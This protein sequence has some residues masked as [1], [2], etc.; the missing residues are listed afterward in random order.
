ML[1]KIASSLSFA[2]LAASAYA[3]SPVHSRVV[4]AGEF[5][6]AQLP[7]QNALMQA[8]ADYNIAALMRTGALVRPKTQAAI[9]DLQ[10]PLQPVAGFDQSG[11]HGI[12]N[13]VDHDARFPG[14][15]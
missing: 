7:E 9:N 2:L 14:F 11:Y 13:F 15:V 5:A 4:S 3:Q 10:W 12:S 1:A 8:Q 6:D